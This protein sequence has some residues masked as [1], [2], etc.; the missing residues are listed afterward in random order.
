M[1]KKKILKT[2]FVSIAMLGI[3]MLVIAASYQQ[4]NKYFHGVEIYLN[5]E[6]EYSFLEKK[7]IEQWLLTDRNINLETSK[8]EDLDLLKMEEIAAANPW[9]ARA[10]IYIDN[11][12]RLCVDIKQREPLARIF[13]QSGKSYYMDKHLKIMPLN[14]G[15]AYPAPVFTNTPISQ[16]DSLNEIILTKVAYVSERIVNDSFW[17]AQI[18]QI[19]MLEDHSFIAI[20]L[21]GNHQIII[22]DTSRLD[23][24]L[25]NLFAF[26]DQ[27]YETIGW[28]AYEKIDLRFQGQV[29]ASPTLSKV[30]P[31]IDLSEFFEEIPET[32][33]ESEMPSD[34]KLPEHDSVIKNE[35]I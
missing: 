23:E 10:D 28:E 2:V 30:P 26:Y 4:K 9:V 34:T 12:K 17:N 16:N 22:G 18:T 11:Q 21:I 8:M 25:F 31:K 3:L 24:K 27:I 35:N 33:L 13:D 5:E 15:Y 32:E 7:D 19:E 20:P 14:I 6:S 1:K 29:V